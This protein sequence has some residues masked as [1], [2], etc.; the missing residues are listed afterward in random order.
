MQ[1]ACKFLP[2]RVLLLPLVLFFFLQYISNP[3]PSTSSLVSFSNSSP[4]DKG[5]FFFDLGHPLLNRV[6][7]SFVKAPDV[8]HP[9]VLS[10]ETGTIVM[11]LEALGISNGRPPDET[12]NLGAPVILERPGSPISKE[13]Q[14]RHANYTRK[15]LSVMQTTKERAS[16]ATI[17]A[18]KPCSEDITDFETDLDMNEVV[19][20]DEDCT[21]MLS[22]GFAYW[23]YPTDTIARLSLGASLVLSGRPC[24]GIDDFIQKLEYEGL[25]QICFTC[26]IYGHTKETCP[27]TNQAMEVME[28][29]QV[30]TPNLNPQTKELH[31]PWM[32]VANRTPKGEPYS[33]RWERSSRLGK[34][35]QG[36]PI[37]NTQ[38]KEARKAA[39]EHR[40]DCGMSKKGD[41]HAISILEQGFEQGTSAGSKDDLSRKDQNKSNRDPRNKGVK[42]GKAA[43]SH[44]S[45]KTTTLD[46]AKN[47]SKQIKAY[48]SHVDVEVKEASDHHS[49]Q[50]FKALVKEHQPKV[51]EPFET[52]SSGRPAVIVIS[53]F[54]SI[55]MEIL[56]V[57]NQFINGMFRSEEDEKWRQFTAVYAS[58]QRGRRKHLWDQLS[59]FDPGEDTPW[60]FANFIH[61]SGL[62]DLGFI[63]LPYTWQ[64]N[65][66]RQRLYGCL[67]NPSWLDKFPG[68]TVKH[69][70]RIGSDH[71]PL[72]LQTTEE[73][74][75][76]RNRPFRFITA[77]QE[78]EQFKQF[79]RPTWVNDRN[80]LENI[81]AFT[82]ASAD[83]NRDVF[84]H[85]GKR[86]KQLLA[87][88]RDIDKKLHQKHS[89]YLINLESQLREELMKVLELEESLWKQKSCSQWT[90]PNILDDKGM[91]KALSTEASN[92]LGVQ[93]TKEEIKATFFNMGALKAPGP[94]GL[95]AFFFQHNWD[96]VGDSICKYIE[97]IFQNSTIPPELNKILQI[98]WNGSMADAFQ[99]Q[100]GIREGDPL[101]PYLFVPCMERNAVA[102]DSPLEDNGSIID[103]SR[104][105]QMMSILA[106]QSERASHVQEANLISTNM[107]E[108]RNIG[109][110]PAIDWF[111]VNTDAGR[112]ATNGMTIAWGQGIPQLEVET[113]NREAHSLLNNKDENIGA[114]TIISHIR[115]I[116][117]REHYSHVCREGNQVADSLAKIAT[118]GEFDVHIIHE[119]PQMVIKMLQD[120]GHTQ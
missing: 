36:L 104:R 87:R 120:E 118:P 57:S 18:R 59:K 77:W 116:E 56:H 69:L 15:S 9:A 65:N 92:S 67:G 24:I 100:R 114:Q 52:R 47:I 34:H 29:Q 26:G 109:T 73:R 44:S 8:F 45:L 86:K 111:K 37:C 76:N 38:P 10:C 55:D 108:K 13:D 83:W 40:F 7:D 60:Q 105:L 14:K 82:E 1:E 20:N 32:V 48:T 63:G 58:P 6:A 41:H 95:N 79:L 17:A 35:S 68:S 49:E 46:W 113:D 84:G 62:T 21:V 85:I 4:F 31:G 89:E 25:R 23:G 61:N 96:I 11:Y 72:L 12:P 30:Q 43:A 115:S 117:K 50:I 88:L 74:K 64:R 53:K 42:I 71:R 103:R 66:L 107:E 80:I 97:G 106:N 78:H 28:E 39:I 33:K 110:K 51:V 93:V 91:F 119:T 27:T 99:P 70:E 98:L 54:D 81:Q 22:Y 112:N 94:D 2:A 90:T 5:G 75:R 102:F 16:Y 101:S 3:T 19:V